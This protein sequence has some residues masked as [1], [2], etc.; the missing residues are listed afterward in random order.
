MLSNLSNA[1]RYLLFPTFS[2]AISQ[3]D[4]WNKKY[5]CF[6]GPTIKMSSMYL[7]CL[8][9]KG[10]VFS[11]GFPFLYSNFKI[12]LVK[13]NSVK[14]NVLHKRAFSYCKLKFILRKITLRSRPA[15]VL[16][17]IQSFFRR[18]WYETESYMFPRFYKNKFK[19]LN[20]MNSI[21][22]NP[23]RVIFKNEFQ[24]YPITFS[25]SMKY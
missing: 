12:S 19:L 13:Y 24:Y 3:R 21:M 7:I 5:V 9:I 17:R 18:R 6:Y 14:I 10:T 2:L 25:I 23:R 1:A 16:R 4:P 11:F 22:R 15:S 8:Y 20:G